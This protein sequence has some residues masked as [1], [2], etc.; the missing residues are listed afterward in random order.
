MAIELVTG[1]LGSNHIDAGDVRALLRGIFGTGN[2]L[3]SGSASPTIA[4]AMTVKV[5]RMELVMNGDHFRLDGTDQFTFTPAS[6]GYW[7]MDT[8]SISRQSGTTEIASIAVVRGTPS[9]SQTTALPAYVVD[10]TNVKNFA[11]YHVLIYQSEC[12]S[13]TFVPQKIGTI[14]ITK[15]YDILPISMGGT[16]VGNKTDLLKY[17]GLSGKVGEIQSRSQQMPTV[18][19][20]SWTDLTSVD[21]SLWVPSG[22]WIVKAYMNFTCNE[23]CTVGLQIYNETD[24]GSY[25]TDSK[26]FAVDPSVQSVGIPVSVVHFGQLN[27]AKKLTVRAQVKA[28]SGR[29]V[30]ATVS[31]GYLRCM[32]IV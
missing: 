29:N 6:Q 4:P 26:Y 2:Y 10:S 21:L 5:P 31:G 14:D 20:G 28:L 22:I 12:R 25:G 15:E 8:I 30:Q 16:G 1:H 32:R 18:C 3:L 13:I 23:S 24:G 9:T 11:L 27:E 17:L 7:R 19:G